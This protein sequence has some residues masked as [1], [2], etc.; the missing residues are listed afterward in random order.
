[1][2]YQ[3]F[4]FLFMIYQRGRWIVKLL[5]YELHINPTNFI[6][7]QGLAKLLSETNCKALELHQ[8]FTQ[9]DAPIIQPGQDNLQVSETYSSSPWY[10]NIIYFH[11]LLEDKG[12]V[13]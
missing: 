9:S 6:K 10:N 11:K 1:M 2:I 3:F 5:E 4:L 7:E 13:S 8:T 12:Q